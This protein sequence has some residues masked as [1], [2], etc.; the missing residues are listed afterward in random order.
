MTWD[1]TW[2][3]GA[4]FRVSFKCIVANKVPRQRFLIHAHSQC[5]CYFGQ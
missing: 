4:T 3:S 5:L 2:F 1:M